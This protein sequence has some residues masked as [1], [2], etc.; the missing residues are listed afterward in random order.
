MNHRTF[1]PMPEYQAGGSR[2][3]VV[4]PVDVEGGGGVPLPL[5]LDPGALCGVRVSHRNISPRKK[6]LKT[7][8]G[9]IVIFD[10]LFFCVIKGLKTNPCRARNRAYRRRNGSNLAGTK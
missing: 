6:G 1:E 10:N 4:M 2:A 9:G 8:D 7:S 3:A 5:S